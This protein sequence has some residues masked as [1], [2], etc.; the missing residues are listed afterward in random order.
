[1]STYFDKIASELL[2]DSYFHNFKY[3]KRDSS[4]IQKASYGIYIIKLEHWNCLNISL[5][6]RPHYGVRF[7][8]LSSWF[9]KFS[10]KKLTDQRNGWYVGFNGRMLEKQNT[11]EF[12]YYETGQFYKDELR[13]LRDDIIECSQ[14]VFDEYATLEKAYQNKITPILE[15]TQKLPNVGADW[16]FENLTLCKILHPEKYEELKEIHLRHA[17]EMNNKEEPNMSIYYPRLKEILSYMENQHFK[18]H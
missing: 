15:G 8:V 10:F 17:K 14:Y 1:M 3:R 5:T 11:Y 4:L 12:P 9:E 16:F 13:K 6:I 18:I 2:E 7:E